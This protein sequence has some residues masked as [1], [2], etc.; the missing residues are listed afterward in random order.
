M[1][2]FILHFSN[3]WHLYFFKK[4]KKKVQGEDF[5]KKWF[6]ILREN[7]FA[8]ALS[9]EN[10]S[11]ECGQLYQLY[12]TRFL[13]IDYS[14]PHSLEPFFKESAGGKSPP[15]PFFLKLRGLFFQNF[16]ENKIK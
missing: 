6:S 7:F 5:K 16:P 2:T 1:S 13:N 4:R 15:K 14:G 12:K 8:A 9:L 3:D 11:S 10:G